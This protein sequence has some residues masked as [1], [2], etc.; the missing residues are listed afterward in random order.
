MQS[1]LYSLSESGAKQQGGLHVA[2]KWNFGFHLFYQVVEDSGVLGVYVQWDA[3]GHDSDSDEVV[4]SK[5][6][7]EDQ[8]GE[9]QRHKL[10]HGRDRDGDESAELANRHHDERASN[11]THYGEEGHIQQGNGVASESIWGGK[12]SAYLIQNWKAGPSWPRT[13]QATKR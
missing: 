11:I 13:T 10:A 8:E 1:N 9:E 4:N 3:E 5:G 7:G 2:H 12:A 6:F